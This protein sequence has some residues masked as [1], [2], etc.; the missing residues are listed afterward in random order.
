MLKS[1]TA[2]LLAGT[3]LGAA[4]NTSVSN[5]PPGGPP[6]QPAVGSKWQ[7]MT[8]NSLSIDPYSPSTLD[9]PIYDVDLFNTPQHVIQNLHQQG[10]RV[11]CYFSAGTAE[12]WRPDYREFA[13][14]DMG[15]N[16]KCWPGE[17]WVNIKSQTVWGVISRRIQQ[18]AQKGCDAIDPDNIDGFSNSVAGLTQQ[19]SIQFV[20]RM[21]AEARQYGM[22]IGL[23]NSEQILPQV[24]NDIQF[25]VNEACQVA[26][27]CKAYGPFLAQGKPVFHIE[28]A[29]IQGGANGQIGVSS[30][31]QGLQGAAPEQ[32]RQVLCLEKPLGAGNVD[33]GAPPTAF[34][35][36]I[37]GRLLDGWALYCDGTSVLTPT[38]NVNTGGPTS[39]FCEQ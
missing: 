21:A 19:D 23:K 3:A 2:S 16:V 33:P 34:S 9:I 27:D 15:Q 24:Q 20:K 22:S 4:L 5:L 25:A 36:I 10:K 13:R 32:I 29:R 11:I 37:K 35:T 30:T 7:I 17:K 1:L 18:A 8:K 26:G 12:E 38:R 31:T 28:Y 14:N 39:G 6:W